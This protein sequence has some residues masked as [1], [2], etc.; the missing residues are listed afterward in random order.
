M[1]EYIF[2]KKKKGFLCYKTSESCSMWLKYQIFCFKN[3]L[4]CWENKPLFGIY[5]LY[6]FCIIPEDILI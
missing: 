4:D 3:E 5:W 1:H 6:D 2:G